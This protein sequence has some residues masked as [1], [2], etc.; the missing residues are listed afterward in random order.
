MRNKIKRTRKGIKRKP[1]IKRYPL[2]SFKSG[3]GEIQQL[4]RRLRYV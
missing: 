1:K 4:I 3:P 2:D